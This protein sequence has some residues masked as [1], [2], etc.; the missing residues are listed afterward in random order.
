MIHNGVNDCADDMPY[1][2]FTLR[3]PLE[4]IQSA[5][6]YDRRAVHVDAAVEYPNDDYYIDRGQMSLYVECPFYTLNDLAMRGLAKDGPAPEH[7]KR[8]ARDTIKGTQ[9]AGYHLY[10]NHNWFLNATNALKSSSKSKILVIRLKHMVD[11]WNSAEDILSVGGGGES[12]GKTKRRM[13]SMPSLN[14][15]GKKTPKLYD[16]QHLSSE[17]RTLL[18]EALCTEIRLYKRILNAA[19]NLSP[20]DKRN[21]LNE[22]SQSCPTIANVETCDDYDEV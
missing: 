21:T 17:A 16:D 11:D 8:R 4:R 2:L 15:G 1:Y 22:L 20:D 13:E 19:L 6:V 5:Y 3:D 10:Y 14:E 18:C 12:T 7:C 9:R